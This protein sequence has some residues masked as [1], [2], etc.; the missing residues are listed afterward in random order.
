LYEK[1]VEPY[2]LLLQA[3]GES[4]WPLSEGDRRVCK[5]AARQR[6]MRAMQEKLWY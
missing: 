3:G 4:P 2:N 5:Q 1:A 6:K